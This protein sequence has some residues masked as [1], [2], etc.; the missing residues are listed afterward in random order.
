[1]TIL[2]T[3]DWPKCVY[4][5]DIYFKGLPKPPGDMEFFFA[6]PMDKVSSDRKAPWFHPVP[7][8]KNTLGGLLQTFVNKQELKRRRI[9]ACELLGL[10]LC[11][12]LE[13][14]KK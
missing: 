5:L 13:C 2:G 3:N 10:Q 8:G 6:K 14:L 7:V 1:M 12:L 11:L 4:L 9:T